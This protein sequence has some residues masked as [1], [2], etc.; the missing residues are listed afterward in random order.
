MAGLASLHI[1]KN[2]K[3][4]DLCK[5]FINFALSKE[6]QEN[7]SRG[8]VALPT[9]SK[10]EVDARTAGRIPK[11]ELL[12]IVDWEKIVPQM[13]D[14]AE[15]WNRFDR[16]LIRHA[17]PCAGHPRLCIGQARKTRMA[18]TELSREHFHVLGRPS[19]AP[20]FSNQPNGRPTGD[21]SSPTRPPSHRCSARARCVRPSPWYVI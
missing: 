3:S 13:P 8:V 12:H 10:A 16:L 14:L 19:C 1:V 11:T 21:R 5:K 15:K 6:A 18:G 20:Y 2:S 4:I 7:F 9:N 17:R